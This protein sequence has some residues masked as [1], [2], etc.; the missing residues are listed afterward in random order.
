MN[1][2]QNRI[3]VTSVRRPVIIISL[4]TVFYIEVHNQYAKED[5]P[6]P[7]HEFRCLQE[8]RWALEPGSWREVIWPNLSMQ[9]SKSNEAEENDCYA[10]HK[11]CI[12]LV[13][14]RQFQAGFQTHTPITNPPSLLFT[15][16]EHRCDDQEARSDSTCGRRENT[17]WFG[18]CISI[19]SQR[20]R[21]NRTAN[22]PPKDLHAACDSK[23]IDHMKI[24]MLQGNSNGLV[25]LNMQRA[26]SI[27]HPFPHWKLL[28]SQ[29]LRILLN[30]VSQ[31]IRGK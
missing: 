30:E 29:V 5:L 22:K 1:A 26:S 27:P 15:R 11:D 21:M 31:E 16:I 20:P 10:I 2:H 14:M 7:R 23:A 6:L 18:Y 4:W 8:S 13:W 17:T 9:C 28:Q 19:P 12:Y 3:E 25:Q 24:L